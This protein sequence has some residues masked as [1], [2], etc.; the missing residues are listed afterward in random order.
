M[1]RLKGKVAIVTGSG[2]GIGRCIALAFAREGA[3]VVVNDVDKEV[4]ETVR[5]E[6]EVAGGR[7]ITCAIGVGTKVAADALV[8]SAVSDLG[9][10]HI[11]VNT[12]GI[13]RDAMIHKM[14]EEDW[15]EVIKVH[16]RGLFLNTQASLRILRE[17]KYGKIINVTSVSGTRGNIGQV[18]YATA[19][20]G[21]VGF[22]LTCAREVAR[23]K[24]NVNAISPIASTRM[25]NAIPD[26][27]R[28]EVEEGIKRE[29]V[30]QR[31]GTPEDVAP[32]AVFLASDESIYLT[33]QIIE[34]TGTP[35]ILL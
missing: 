1:K 4:A 35:M 33:G 22:T 8:D 21:V 9:G 26:K 7:A 13:T 12:A 15:D 25:F 5:N 31:M 32:L 11:L 30:L 18:N 3:A 34:A 28:L 14:T 23:Y 27:I 6:I 20:M 29:S 2:R 16:L 24:I 10:L 19:K 17:Q